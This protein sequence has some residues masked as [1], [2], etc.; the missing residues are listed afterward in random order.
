MQH[1]KEVQANTI[2]F[3]VLRTSCLEVWRIHFNV[4]Y[5]WGSHCSKLKEG[6]EC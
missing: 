2:L 1:D 3:F 4:D 6:S 5:F